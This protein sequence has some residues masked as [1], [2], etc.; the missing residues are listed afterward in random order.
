MKYSDHCGHWP[1]GAAAAAVVRGVL[2]L[3]EPEPASPRATTRR[4][5]STARPTRAH[6]AARSAAACASRTSWYTSRCAGVKR[7]LTGTVR[8]T[9]AA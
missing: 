1:L 7:P 9:S 3:D 8:V 5:L 6:H 2:R 4:A